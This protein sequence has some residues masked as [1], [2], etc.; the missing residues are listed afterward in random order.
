MLVVTVVFLPIIL[1]YTGWVY[2]AARP[3]DGGMDHQRPPLILLRSRH[4]VLQ[5]DSGFGICV[6]ICG[7]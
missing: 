7:A 4:V 5:L 1:I 3:G 6:R 2:R